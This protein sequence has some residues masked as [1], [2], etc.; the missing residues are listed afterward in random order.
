M[1]EKEPGL[2]VAP[3]SNPKPNI[4]GKIDWKPTQQA[5]ILHLKQA[6]MSILN[7]M[8]SFGIDPKVPGPQYRQMKEIEYRT[9]I[10]F[11]NAHD[12]SNRFRIKQQSFV[13]EDS[14]KTSSSEA[15]PGSQPIAA[16]S[17]RSSGDSQTSTEEETTKA[18]QG[19]TAGS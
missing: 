3:L 17:Q 11:W 12:G 5:W 19:Q 6:A 4:A 16:D 9:A 13:L 18:S 7:E 14:G 2:C 15:H 8:P 1:R 10:D